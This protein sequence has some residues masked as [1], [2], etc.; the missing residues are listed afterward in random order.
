MFSTNSRASI[1]LK[2]EVYSEIT[3]AIEIN[4]SDLVYP[5]E[6]EQLE[7]M[8]FIVDKKE[9]EFNNFLNAVKECRKIEDTLHITLLTTT[10]CNFACK[11]CFENGISKGYYLNEDV[12]TA[13]ISYLGKYL[14]DNKLIKKLRIE[15]FG[16]EPTHC[17][18]L[19]VDTLNKV[20]SISRF[21]DVQLLTSIITNGYLFDKDKI[22]DLVPFNF[23]IVQFTL[24]GAKDYH[25]KRRFTKTN[26]PTYDVIINNMKDLLQISDN[27]YLGIRINCYDDNITSIPKLVNDLYQKLGNSRVILTFAYVS[28]AT[29]NLSDES[30]TLHNFIDQLSD[31]YKIAREFGFLVSERNYHDAYCLAKRKNYLILHPSGDL[32]QCNF[33]IGKDSYKLGNVFEY[34]PINNIFNIELYQYCIEKK[35][36]FLPMCHAGCIKKSFLEYGDI[37]KV[38]CLIENMEELNKTFILK[39]MKQ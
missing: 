22:N 7:K 39:Q 29:N 13:F 31:Y 17:W 36:C 1:T 4:K 11:Y 25:D 10:A 16:G 23:D 21:H 28:D 15:L 33:F 30:F 2:K 19:V 35:C 37:S 9:N 20:R 18:E 12:V 26:E 24:D 14:S 27:V 6:I 3:D 38:Y 5:K 32:Y 8:R 34:T